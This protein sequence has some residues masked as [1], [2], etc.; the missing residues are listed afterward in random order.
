MGYRIAYENIG[1]R[2]DKPKRSWRS[3]M[4]VSCV[5]ALLTGAITIKSV[6]LKWVQEILIPGDPAVTAAALEEMVSDLR[7]GTSFVDA[8]T[9]FCQE[10]IN[11]GLS[12]E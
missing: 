7:Q 6:G 1:K 10:I 4:A 12:A 5:A 9:A 8:V 11:H 3:V 2:R